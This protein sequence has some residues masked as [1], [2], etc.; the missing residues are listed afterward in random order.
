MWD[1]RN[2]ENR[3]EF[4]KQSTNGNAGLEEQEGPDTEER[5]TDL[6]QITSEPRDATDL[7]YEIIESSGKDQ[8]ET[9]EI[10]EV[11]ETEMEMRSCLPPEENNIVSRGIGGGVSRS[12]KTKYSKEIEKIVYQNSTV[13]LILKE[14]RKT[15]QIWNFAVR[16]LH[17]RENPILVKQIMETNELEIGF[18]G[19]PSAPD[20]PYGNWQ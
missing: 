3:K 6:A 16:T 15:R 8:N 11:E 9:T 2:E 10:T 14:K 5:S 12:D 7:V 1:N 13:A 20:V 4:Q 17:P 19:I 18:P